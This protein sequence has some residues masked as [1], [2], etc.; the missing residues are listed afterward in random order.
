[1]VCLYHNFTTKARLAHI[2]LTAI[3]ARVLVKSAVMKVLDVNIK[4]RVSNKGGSACVASTLS[5]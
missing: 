3:L 1:M 4:S 2:R 5:G